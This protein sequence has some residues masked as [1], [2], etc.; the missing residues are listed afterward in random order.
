M[1]INRM[2]IFH[3][4]DKIKYPNSQAT[5]KVVIGENNPQPSTTSQEYDAQANNVT[6]FNIIG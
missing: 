2:P 1:V 3:S 6:L 5:N 4:I